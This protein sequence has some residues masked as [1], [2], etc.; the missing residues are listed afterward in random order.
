MDRH[1]KKTHPHILENGKIPNSA[2][3]HVV[4]SEA[5]IL[6]NGAVSHAVPPWVRQNTGFQKPEI[7][8]KDDSANRNED[9]QSGECVTVTVR[10]E[11]RSDDDT[12]NSESEDN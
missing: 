7:G 2:F 5:E 9:S 10:R 8:E 6:A 4:K 3:E 1:I 12:T 11:Y